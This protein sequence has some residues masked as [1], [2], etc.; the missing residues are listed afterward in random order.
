MFLPPKT[1]AQEWVGVLI[2][3]PEPW[4]TQLTEARLALGDEAAH[5]VPAHV[6]LVPPLAVNI[7][8]REQIVRH[9][10]K[11]ASQ[12]RP[13][14]IRLCGTG[15]FRPVS[16]VV[17]LDVAQ[18]RAECETLADEIRSGPLFYQPRFPYHPHVT[19]AQGVG[20]SAL[21]TAESRWE[22]FTAEW[23]APGFRLDSI[24]ATG[25]YASR[26]IFNFGL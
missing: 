4:V 5:N 8:D 18:G 2:A 3:I 14:R 17:F 11:V 23:T 24:D 12:T 1:D 7:S 25:R 19:L 16:P 20:E 9:L 15:S 22:G 6:T 13:F 10:Q 21:D 26:A